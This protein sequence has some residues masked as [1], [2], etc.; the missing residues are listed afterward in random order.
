MTLTAHEN[1]LRQPVVAF[2]TLVLTWN[3]FPAPM[4]AL[5]VL[6]ECFPH[7]THLFGMN[8]GIGD[9]TSVHDP[10]GS[11]EEP[12][13]VPLLARTSLPGQATTVAELGPANTSTSSF[14]QLQC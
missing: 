12:F 2:L 11:L 7:L 9:G 13:L 1:V 10:I 14:N 5:V 3:I 8:I 6:L 4:V